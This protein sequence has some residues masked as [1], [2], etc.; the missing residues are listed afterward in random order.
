[1]SFNF[2]VGRAWSESDGNCLRLKTLAV[3]IETI[4]KG[5]FVASG[6]LVRRSVYS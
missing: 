2:R 4:G 3:V 6:D 1:M 5:K